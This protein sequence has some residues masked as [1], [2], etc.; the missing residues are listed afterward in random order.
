[1][2]T[3]LSLVYEGWDRFRESNRP[4]HL[5]FH[6]NDRTGDHHWFIG[7]GTIDFDNFYAALLNYAP[8][9]TISL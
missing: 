7:S 3:S 8:H 6:D 4:L 2:S 1:M 9:A 5:H